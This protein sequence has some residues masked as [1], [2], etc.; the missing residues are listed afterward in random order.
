VLE[1]PQLLLLGAFAGFTIFLGIP[2]AVLHVSSRKKGFLNAFAIGILIFLIIDVFSSAWY[3][4]SNSVVSAISGK[5][6]TGNAM[7]DVL[8]MFGGLGLGLLGLTLYGRLYL[9]DTA[10]NRSINQTNVTSIGKT[11]ELQ[12]LNQVNS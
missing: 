1:Y 9:R 6:A 3:S 10:L 2:V 8:S 4:A 11:H 5:T 12:L 7:I